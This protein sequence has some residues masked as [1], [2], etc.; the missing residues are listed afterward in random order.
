LTFTLLCIGMDTQGGHYRELRCLDLTDEPGAG[1]TSTDL[2][3]LL[4]CKRR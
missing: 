4:T 1:A 2:L 3:G